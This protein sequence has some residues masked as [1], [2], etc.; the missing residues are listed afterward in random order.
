MRRIFAFQQKVETSSSGYNLL[1]SNRINCCSNSNTA[2]D[3]AVVEG[4]ATFWN[5]WTE[6]ETRLQLEMSNYLGLQDHSGE[7]GITPIK[8]IH[9]LDTWDCGKTILVIRLKQIMML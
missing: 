5:T 3:L 6:E 8:H 2:N 7:R 1:D 4:S 9:Q